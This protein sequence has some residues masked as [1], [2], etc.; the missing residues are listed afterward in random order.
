MA[1]YIL[2]SPRAVLHDNGLSARVL[3]VLAILVLM[4]CRGVSRSKNVGWT[5]MASAEREPIMGVWGRSPQ[6]GPGAEHL[7][8][9]SRG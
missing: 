1:G 2:T 6:Q 4:G 5:H 9:R 3:F 8:R 7:V